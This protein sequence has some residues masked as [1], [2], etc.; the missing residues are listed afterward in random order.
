MVIIYGYYSRPPTPGSVGGIPPPPSHPDPPSHAP[1]SPFD[2]HLVA[3]QTPE[4][5]RPAI[6]ALSVADSISIL[7]GIY[8]PRG[9][10]PMHAALRGEVE[11]ELCVG[12]HHH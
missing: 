2:A 7:R 1:P 6:G 3:Y 5:L 12:I 11:A 10:V 8:V 4:G 9:E